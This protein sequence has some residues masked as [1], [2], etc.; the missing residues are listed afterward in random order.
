M[1]EWRLGR[2]WSNEELARRLEEASKLEESFSEPVTEMTRDAGW[3]QYHSESV[4][5]HENPGTPATDGPFQRGCTVVT[6]YEF[7]DPRIVIGH[8]DPDVPL[9]GRNMLLEI[10]AF[11]S[12]HYL[13]AVRVNAVKSESTD[14]YSACGFRYDTLEGHI[15]RGFEWF[16][17][18][19]DHTSGEIRFRIEAAWRPG[20]FPNAWSRIGFAV[21]GPRYQRLWHRR[22]HGLLSRLMRVPAF[23][24][25]DLKDG[26]LLHTDPDIIF[27]RYRAHNA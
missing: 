9:E 20:D 21:V 14:H 23:D 18:T 10:R 1:A 6:S 2:G 7:S 17:L 5:G 3:H 15:E 25:L 8:F 22:A 4:V 11:R 13:S 12:L 16:V 19:K 26:S 24:P 27:K